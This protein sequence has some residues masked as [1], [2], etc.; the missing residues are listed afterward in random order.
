MEMIINNDVKKTISIIIAFLIVLTGAY[1]GGR[2][3]TSKE[4]SRQITNIHAARDSIKMYDITIDKLQLRVFEKNAFI[5]S[6]KDAI[7]AGILEN[8]R[9]K[10]LH[11]KDVIANA[12]LE[13]RIHALE[14]SLDL[15]PG[16]NI[17]VVHDT[18]TG[19][20]KE[21]VEIPFTLL[22][23]KSSDLLLSAGMDS[24]RKAWYDITVPFSGEI[25]IGYEKAGFLKTKPVGIFITENKILDITNMDIYI[26]E[27]SKKFYQKW[28]VHALVGG[29]IVGTLCILTNN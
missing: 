10:K 24:L 13:G 4:R 19:E 20:D 26:K 18:A 16:T 15:V 1:L 28:W 14:D 27:D 3:S 25:T 5:L 29:G 12:K 21:C 6:Q 17:I 23:I 7:T 22:D 11:I 9:L 8:E 2:W